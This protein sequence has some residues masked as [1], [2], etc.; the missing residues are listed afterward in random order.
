MKKLATL[1][2]DGHLPFDAGGAAVLLLA[3]LALNHRV[4]RTASVART[5]PVPRGTAVP[6]PI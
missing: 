3:V 4:W 6:R 5:A 1:P 2:L